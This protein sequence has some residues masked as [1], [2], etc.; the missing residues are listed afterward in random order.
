MRPEKELYSVIVNPHGD[1]WLV[2]EFNSRVFE[3]KGQFDDKDRAQE[4]ADELNRQCFS[5]Y[6]A[7]AKCKV[8]FPD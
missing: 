2:G 3:V 8:V 5:V 1:G 7:T 6:S 4:F